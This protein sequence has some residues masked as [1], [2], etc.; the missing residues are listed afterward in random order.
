MELSTYNKSAEQ[1]RRFRIKRGIYLGLGI[2]LIALGAIGIVLPLIP[3]TPFWLLASLCLAR[4]SQKINDWLQGTTV[5]RTQVQPVLNGEGI[6][7]KS[8]ISILATVWIL[9]LI[10]FFRTDLFALKVLAISLG[11]IKTAVFIRLKTAAPRAMMSESA[12]SGREAQPAVKSEP[13]GSK[14]EAQRPV[15]K[16]ASGRLPRLAAGSKRWIALTIAVKLCLLLLNIWFAFAL[17]QAIHGLLEG[18]ARS[19]VLHQL[20]YNGLA[21]IVLRLLLSPLAALGAS[22]SS[23]SI[24]LNLR[25]DVFRKLLRLETSY[26]N[27]MGTSQVV[28]SAVDGVEALESYF[29]SYL[30]Q[31]F[32]SL[33]APIVLFVFAVGLDLRTALVLLLI[34]PLIPLLLA[35]LLKIARKMSAKHFKSYQTLGGL[36][37]ESLQGLSTLK[38]FNRDGERAAMLQEKSEGFRKTTMRVLAMQLNSLTLIDLIA[39]GGAAA[40]IA[41]AA[42]SFAAGKLELG[43]AVVLLLLSVEFFLPLRLLSSYFH[44]AMNGVAAAN[45]IFELLDTPEPDY[46]T[47]DQQGAHALPEQLSLRLMN[48]CFAYDDRSAA[49]QNVSIEIEAGCTT[50]IVGPSGSG[51]S[52]VAAMLSLMLEPS[53]G[54]ITLDEKP[55]R[56]YGVQK[57]RETIGLVPQQTYIFTGTVADNLW[58]GRPEATEIELMQACEAAGLSAFITASPLGL[59]TPVGE[60]GSLLSGGQRQKLGIARALLKDARL[61]IFDEATSSVD[62][63][64]EEEI[65]LTI[66][67]AAKERT[68]LIISHRLSTI[69]RADRIYV[70]DKGK[71]VESGTHMELMAMQGL[72]YE[73]AVR[74]GELLAGEASIS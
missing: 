52:T 44:V 10:I 32:Y 58:M 69:V 59:L 17:G 35:L 49:L 45:K 51:K 30:P 24:R 14:R 31:L 54:C 62:A 60:G 41:A 71:V 47:H 18:T 66:W 63:E 29:G 48:V 74:Q 5:F 50:A 28:S 11:V 22:R 19:E 13:T 25:L 38:L 37:L 67:N 68:T 72:Y 57:V 16:P 21:V 42:S 39:Y 65:G 23:N 33:L 12:G 34:S 56:S 7:R 4:S 6:T 26:S 61:Y 3:T 8:K 43:A 15:H 40:G 46:N 20:L 1:S 53:S 70:M 36:F 27:T 64:S 55:L 2:L 9:L 73:L